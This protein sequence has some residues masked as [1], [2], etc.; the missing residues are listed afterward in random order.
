[1][2]SFFCSRLML[3][4]CP[5]PQRL[6]GWCVVALCVIRACFAMCAAPRRYDS[7]TPWSMCLYTSDLLRGDY[8]I[9]PTPVP[10]CPLGGTHIRSEHTHPTRPRNYSWV[11]FTCLLQLWAERVGICPG[12]LGS[13]LPSWSQHV[14][15]PQTWHRRAFESGRVYVLHSAWHI[16]CRWWGSA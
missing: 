6:L 5:I 14:G 11:S 15:R 9:G 12:L 8:H 3:Q 7:G 13:P 1:V 10:A 16:I 2:N 4:W